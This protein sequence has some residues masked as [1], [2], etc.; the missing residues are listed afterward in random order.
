MFAGQTVGAS[1]KMYI[2]DWNEVVVCKPLHHLHAH[3]TQSLVSQ[4]TGSVRS[5]VHFI[6]P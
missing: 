2:L 1:L 6:R 4:L 3:V 5:N